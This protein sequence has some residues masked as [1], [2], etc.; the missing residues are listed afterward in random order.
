MKKKC[1]NIWYKVRNLQE[2]FCLLDQVSEFVL[3]IGISQINQSM[4]H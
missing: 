4:K 1:E 2:N 3:K